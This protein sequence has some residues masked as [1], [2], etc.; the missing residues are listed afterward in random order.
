MPQSNGDK[1]LV[2]SEDAAGERLDRLLQRLLPGMGLRGRRRL[3]E[4]GLVEVDGRARAAGFRAEA[5]QR[6]NVRRADGARTDQPPAGLRVIKIGERH[7]AVFKPAG[8][9]SES[10]AGGEPGMDAFLPA[11]LGREDARLVNRLDLPT[12]GLVIAAFGPEAEAEFRGLEDAGQVRKEYAALVHG[13]VDRAAVLRFALDTA[14]RKKVRALG[15]DSPDPLRWTEIEPVRHDPAHDQTLVRAVIRK[16]ARHQIRAHL[17]LHGHPIVG[18]GLYGPGGLGQSG[19][20]SRL[21]LHHG[22]IDLPGLSAEVPA[23]WA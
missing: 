22:R 17:A 3:I 8:M 14:D 21:H 13:R 6:I 4:A 7:A 9:H 19:S 10:L 18:D 12:S 15:H 20:T 5:G 11:L 1:I 23:D 16:G 2:V